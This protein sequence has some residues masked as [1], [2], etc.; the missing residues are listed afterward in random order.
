MGDIKQGS[1]T[2]KM[3]E[4]FCRHTDLAPA[5]TAILLSGEGSNAEAILRYC[6]AGKRAFSPELVVTDT[7]RSRAREIAHA[8]GLPLLLSDIRAFYA[9]SGEE[10][11]RLDTP[12][13]RELRRAWS[14]GLGRELDRYGIELVLFAGFMPM[15]S[16]TEKFPCLNVHP[17]DLTV[18][19][20]D[21]SRPFAGLHYKPVEDALC[22][23]MTYLRSSVILAQ[24]YA[25]DG[26]SDMDSGPVIGVS[27]KIPVEIA[28]DTPETLSELRAA[29]SGR[30]PFDRLRRLAES[31]IRRMK[32]LGDHVIFSRAAEDFAR[33]RFALDDG[34]GL[35]FFDGGAWT[36]V[37]SVTYADDGAMPISRETR[38]REE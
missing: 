34:G 25:G 31:H 13:R 19:A 1:P 32:L 7:P 12:R 30:S 26:K 24:P 37:L 17:G 8:A 16:L 22:G 10:S 2:G 28:P 27:R 33:G 6:R 35:L 36:P 29:R 18:T 11:I 3:R 9:S 38:G 23:G 4:L 15:T 21:G 5:R 20:P 14:D